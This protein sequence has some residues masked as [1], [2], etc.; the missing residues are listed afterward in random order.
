MPRDSDG[1]YPHQRAFVDRLKSFEGDVVVSSSTLD[2]IGWFPVKEPVKNDDPFPYD[3]TIWPYNPP[4]RESCSCPYC[5]AGYPLVEPKLFRQSISKGFTMQA[6]IYAMLAESLKRVTSF[7]ERF[8]KPVKGELT[9]NPIF[10]PAR[11]KQLPV[12]SKK[13]AFT[14]KDSYESSN[15]AS[16]ER[17]TTAVEWQL[18]Y[19][20]G[21]VQIIPLE[22]PANDFKSRLASSGYTV[23]DEAHYFK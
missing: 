12:D 9:A 20:A 15:D 16:M 2:A 8:G 19:H 7:G 23:Y 1:L 17:I 3:L 18:K 13:E 10:D 11:Y 6:Q 14:V 22:L 5:E 4:K 21:Q